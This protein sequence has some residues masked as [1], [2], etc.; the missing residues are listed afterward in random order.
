[1]MS[2]QDILKAMNIGLLSISP[3]D[4]T[5]LQACSYDM[6]LASHFTFFE[7]K[8]PISVTGN[9][10]RYYRSVIMSEMTLMPGQ[11]VL[12]STIEKVE[13]GDQIAGRLEGKSSLGRLGLMVHTTAGFIDAGFRGHI[14]L[15]LVNI[16]NVEM[17]LTMAM[18]IAQLSL[19]RLD[20]PTKRPY[21]G[22]YQDQGHAVVSKYHENFE[23]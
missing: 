10:K 20:S 3:F 9:N 18:P 11:M 1:M 19:F 23:D 13:F 14:T 22:K 6:T 17:K 21:Q 7:P 4:E 16:L 8:W 2:D 5:R 12:A 15:E